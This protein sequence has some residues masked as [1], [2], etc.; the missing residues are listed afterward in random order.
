MNSNALILTQLLI[1]LLSQAQSIGQLLRNARAEDRDVTDEELDTLAGKYGR[2][3]MP[4]F[5]EPGKMV[6]NRSQSE[7]SD[8]AA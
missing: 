7:V 1:Q 3:L 2:R 4:R 5:S 6:A 8:A